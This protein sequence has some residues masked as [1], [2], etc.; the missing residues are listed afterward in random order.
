VAKFRAEYSAE[1]ISVLERLDKVSSSRIIRKIDSILD[2][3]S[4]Y[5]ERLSGRPE[6]KLRIGDYRAI[7][8]LDEG[9]RILFVR[10]IGHRRN[11]Y[12]KK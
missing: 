1:S 8:D 10:S 12:S 5:I 4:R 6:F 7:L 9:Q 2:N 11:I 3:P